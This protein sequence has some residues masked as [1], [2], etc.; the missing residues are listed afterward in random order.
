MRLRYLVNDQY[1]SNK[2]MIWK[3]IHLSCTPLHLLHDIQ[4]AVDNE[5]VHMSCLLCEPRNAISSLFCGTKF[6]FEEGVILGA[7]NGEVIRHCRFVLEVGVVVVWM[8]SWGKVE[9]SMM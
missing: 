7:N 9:R 1:E 3:F 5:L 6:I 2:I 8:R 4:A